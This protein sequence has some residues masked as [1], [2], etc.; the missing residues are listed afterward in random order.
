[1]TD[2]RLMV[3]LG[4]DLCLGCSLLHHTG[5]MKDVWCEQLCRRKYKQVK[6]LGRFEDQDITVNI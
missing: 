3:K 6:P 2:E 5:H 4:L 1:M